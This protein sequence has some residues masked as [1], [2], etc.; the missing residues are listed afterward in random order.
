MEHSC[1]CKN[2]III[3]NLTW[4]FE[5]NRCYDGSS[6]LLNSFNLPVFIPELV[7]VVSEHVIGI[8]TFSTLLFFLIYIY[9]LSTFT[10]GRP[11]DSSL[12]PELFFLFEICIIPQFSLCAYWISLYV[13]VDWK[14]W[15]AFFWLCVSHLYYTIYISFIDVLML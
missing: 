14:S 9:F 7:Y 6:P 4:F 2:S 12:M 13:V 10:L 5:G 15:L 3:T 1:F 8:V 11:L